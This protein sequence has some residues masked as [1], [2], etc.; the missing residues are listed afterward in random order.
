MRLQVSGAS[1]TTLRG[2]VWAA[3]A[4]EPSAW[5]MQTTDST[6]G[7]QAPGYVGVEAAV[8]ATVTNAPVSV[9]LDDLRAATP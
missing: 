1:P 5:M 2:K 6:A 7:L 4:A 9:L 8:T 3:S